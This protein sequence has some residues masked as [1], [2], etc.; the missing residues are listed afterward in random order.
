MPITSECT[1]CKNCDKHHDKCNKCNNKTSI[2]YKRCSKYETEQRH[3]P[4]ADPCPPPPCNDTC[5]GN[6]GGKCALCC[7]PGPRGIP[8]R[9]GERGCPGPTGPAGATGDQGV[10]GPKGATGSQGPIGATGPTGDTG[11]TGVTGPQGVTGPKGATGP[12]GPKG[13][14]GEDG[15]DGRDG[16]DCTRC[17]ICDACNDP[18][19]E[20]CKPPRDDCKPDACVSGNIYFDFNPEAPLADG[21]HRYL[22]R[23]RSYDTFDPA[24]IVIPTDGAISKMVCSLTGSREEIMELH[25]VR[26]LLCHRK[27]DPDTKKYKSVTAIAICELTRETGLCVATL[28]TSEVCEC[29]LLSVKIESYGVA[30]FDICVSVC[31][32]PNSY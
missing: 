17:K 12:A 28:C 1:K 30:D 20:V 25:K 9:K 27:Y 15:R 32:E 31:M 11:P 19:K 3:T 23:C 7:R 10:T 5:G 21:C 24:C 14:P 22:G 29:D 8:G 26:I 2:T 4:C 6:C 13:C 16:R 18:C